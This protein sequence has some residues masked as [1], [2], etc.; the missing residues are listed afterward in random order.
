MNGAIA[1][2][3]AAIRPRVDPLAAARA[4]LARFDVRHRRDIKIDLIAY[5]LGAIVMER[6]TGS[7]DARVTRAGDR[8]IIALA[9][10][11]LETTR[12]RFSVAHE[13]A[14]H[15]LHADVDAIERIHGAPFASHAEYRVE[16]E[17]D[18]FASEILLPAVL[19]RPFCLTALPTLDAV[20][21]LARMFDVSLTVAA[22]KWPKLAKT[23]CAFVESSGGLIKR[24]VRS[25][26]F[27]GVAFQRRSLEE[28][29]AA[30]E[31]ERAGGM[32]ATR[33]HEGERGKWG[34]AKAGAAVIEEC[35]TLGDGGPGGKVLTWLW[36]D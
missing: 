20:G 19:A 18:V 13:T 16:R 36:H 6:A 17:A 15:V 10:R 3:A 31:M 14:H 26:A 4:V 8:A 29:T 2:G 28:G 30:L 22:M 33:V 32:G 25:D 27:R 35:V 34:S 7:A 5:E 12:A 24:A 21:D 9:P 11:A 1:E 23:P